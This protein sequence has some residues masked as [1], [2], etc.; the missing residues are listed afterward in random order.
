MDT[1]LT[2]DL[3]GT[4]DPSETSSV[5]T[6]AKVSSTPWTGWTLESGGTVWT[7]GG[8]NTRWSYFSWWSLLPGCS[9]FPRYT[10]ATIKT[11]RAH[12]SNCAISSRRSRWSWHFADVCLKEGR[13][14]VRLNLIIAFSEEKRTW[15]YGMA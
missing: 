15:T 4:E 2:A 11:P 14:I 3:P 13:N 1:S 9:W 6:E 12:W 5:N 8:I 10:I 7:S